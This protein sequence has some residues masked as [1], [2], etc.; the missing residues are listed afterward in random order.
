M[1]DGGTE[2][3]AEHLMNQRPQQPWR[4]K[5]TSEQS[6]SQTLN[7]NKHDL[8]IA[9]RKHHP[10]RKGERNEM[11]KLPQ[12]YTMADNMADKPGVGSTKA[13]L[14][15]VSR[16]LHDLRIVRILVGSKVL[17]GYIRKRTVCNR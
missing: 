9:F 2:F 5:S 10:P 12:A 16:A 15:M 7:I 14:P 6:S 8:Y 17:L 3:D 1:I 11:A 13:S 4:P